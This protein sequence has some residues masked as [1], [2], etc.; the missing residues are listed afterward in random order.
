M[1]WLWLLVVVVFL[2]YI[3]VQH[4]SSPSTM[5][6]LWS[7]TTW[8]IG[9]V[10]LSAP[11][12]VSLLIAIAFYECNVHIHNASA[13]IACRRRFSGIYNYYSSI[14]LVVVIFDAVIKKG[15]NGQN[16]EYEAELVKLDMIE[17]ANLYEEDP[18]DDSKVEK[19]PAL[20]RSSSHVCANRRK[21]MLFLMNCKRT[22]TRDSSNSS[23]KTKLTHSHL[24]L[25][26]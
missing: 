13:L 15:W 4:R 23:C 20:K 2:R 3:I 6:W 22:T 8:W 11:I 21:Q 7:K 12:C 1:H 25:V 26:K 24:K 10:N 5:P 18:K 9:G 16:D 14:S 19:T 17:N